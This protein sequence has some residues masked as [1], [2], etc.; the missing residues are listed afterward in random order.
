MNRLW[1]SKAYKEAVVTFQEEAKERVKVVF[2]L[3]RKSPFSLKIGFPMF[4]T[5]GKVLAGVVGSVSN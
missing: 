3:K 4:N 2:Q 5:N 1:E